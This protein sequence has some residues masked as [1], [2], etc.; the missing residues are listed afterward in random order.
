M[1]A[2]NLQ[3]MEVNAFTHP[4]SSDDQE[5]RN[6]VNGT[7]RKMWEQSFANELEQLAQGIITAKVTNTI[8]FIP[9]TQVPKLK[10][11]HTAR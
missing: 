1:A 11:S 4:I 10:R 8:I 9:K 2:K 6:M 5:Y 7:Y 3:V